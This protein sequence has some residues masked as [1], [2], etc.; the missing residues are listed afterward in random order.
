MK[1]LLVFA[2]V[3]ALLCPAALAD[4]QSQVNAPAHVTDTFQSNT[5]KTVVS[6]DA[7]VT[8]PN[9]DKIPIYLISPRLF[10][11]EEMTRAA[12]DLF[13]ERE[14]AGST[15][16]STQSHTAYDGSTSI[17][18]QAWFGTV[19]EGNGIYFPVS[20]SI[21][22]VQGYQLTNGMMQNTF[23]RYSRWN[24][25]LQDTSLPHYNV[26]GSSKLVAPADGRLPDGCS[27][28]MEEAQE[29]AGAI[30]AQIASHMVYAGCGIKAENARQSLHPGQYSTDID[31]TGLREAWVFYYT[32]MY[33][34]PC[35]FAVSG[36]AIDNYSV[37]CQEESLCVIIDDEG[38]QD[39]YW[40]QPYDIVET[41]QENCSLLPFDS[42]MQV[43]RNILPLTLAS[44]EREGTG[45]RAWIT[46]I[47]LGYLR[48]MRPNQPDTLTLIP[49]W[50][51]YGTVTTSGSSVQNWACHSWLTINATDGTVIDR[52]YGY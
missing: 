1:R 52:S 28:S 27:I 3:C 11:A 43:A 2:L 46:D 38:L 42:V 7:D 33:D 32:P 44:Y 45:A 48:V 50:D 14:W 47:R 18:Y 12:E 8:V 21:M 5:G 16:Y 10:S 24:E 36:L 40:Y 9:V 30:V 4:V 15:E 37:R 22:R 34:L 39:L 23:I 13:G 20:V 51:F 25:E 31:P 17:I 29:H 49:V 26:D 6:I 35:N 41:L 19:E